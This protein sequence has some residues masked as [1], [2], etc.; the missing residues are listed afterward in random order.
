MA[1]APHCRFA[2]PAGWTADSVRWSGGCQAGFAQGRGVLRAYQDGRVV[3]WFYGRY[4]AG[5]PAFGVVDLGQGFM[6]GRFEAGRVV[7]GAERNTLI[8]AF[9]EASAAA[10]ELALA[11][12]RAGNDASARLYDRKA[13]QLAGQMD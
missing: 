9:D 3:R 13:E 11:F 1:G 2:V 7:S 8:E 12:R 10:R 6:A 4:L 5:Q